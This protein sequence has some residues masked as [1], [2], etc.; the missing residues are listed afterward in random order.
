MNENRFLSSS[1]LAKLRNYLRIF[2]L[3][4]VMQTIIEKYFASL[5]IKEILYSIIG[6]IIFFL[7]LW[8]PRAIFKI[9]ILS[10]LK[11]LK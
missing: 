7:L 8:F 3:G 6:C 9:L 2:I 4:Y 11:F 10:S 5:S 1:F